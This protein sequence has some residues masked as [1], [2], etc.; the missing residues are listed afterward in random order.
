MRRIFGITIIISL[1]LAPAISAGVPE[2]MNY[3]GRLTDNS[4]N[5]LDTTV[6]MVFTIYDD[7]TGVVALWTETHASVSVSAGIFNVVM[8]SSNP[9]PDT[10]FDGVD[11][12]LGIRVGT[13]P[14]IAPRTRIISVAY[15]YRALRSDSSDYVLNNGS[16]WIDD[17]IVVRLQDSLNYVGIGTSNPQANLHVHSPFMNAMNISST[18]PLAGI[19][20]Y[21]DN[22]SRGVVGY[23]DLCGGGDANAMTICSEN[24]VLQFGDPHEGVHLTIDAGLVGIGETNPTNKLQVVGQSVPPDP[25]VLFDQT[26]TGRG[27]YVRT[28][29]GFCAMVSESGNHGLRVVEAGRPENTG[30]DGVHVMHAYHDGIH[31]VDAGNNG[32]HVEQAAEWAG[33]FV[34]DGYFSG[35]F[36]IGVDT[37]YEKLEVEGNIRLS[38]GPLVSNIP[39][40]L[41]V[42]KSEGYDEPGRALEIYAGEY[43]DDS[44]IETLR[45]GDLILHGGKGLGFA[46]GNVYIYGGDNLSSTTPIGNIIIAHNG[47][48]SGGNVG[49]GTDIPGTALAVRGLTGTS[50]YNNVRVN[51]ATG[52]FYFES[53]SR[54]YK[55]NIRNYKQDYSAIYQASPKVYIDKASGREEIGYI[56][57]EFDNLGLTDLVIYDDE[58]NPNGLK[59]E[60]IS[61]YLLELMKDREVQMAEIRE[62]IDWM[63]ELLTQMVEANR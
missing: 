60:K 12:F 4:G 44:G 32:I 13:D 18:D 38:A 31:V 1:V 58:G 45:G 27:L 42:K 29:N 28:P 36:G 46:G 63:E 6:S 14:E 19:W 20:F 25:L 8:G 54:K 56:A 37:L 43:S 53:S 15:S 35:Q 17:G 23:G 55:E 9:I 34:G 21:M 41:Y 7:S 33:Y 22:M 10:T 2:L 50:S 26:G 5:P 47:T 24:D 39:L 49:I 3:Q 62:K 61:I 16:G 59:Y 11:R 48:T 30:A 52:D 40:S 57:E 51:T